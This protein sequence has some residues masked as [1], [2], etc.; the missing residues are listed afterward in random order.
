MSIQESVN[1]RELEHII[2]KLK[3]MELSHESLRKYCNNMEKTLVLVNQGFEKIAMK[4]KLQNNGVKNKEPSIELE[5]IE[6]DDES[7]SR[8]KTYP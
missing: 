8:S 1:A 7:S 6:S 3:A 2:K 5:E 4:G